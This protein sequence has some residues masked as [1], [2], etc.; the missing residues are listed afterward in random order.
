MLDAI[1][2]L[3]ADALIGF[4]TAG[5]LK[6]VSNADPGSQLLPLVTRCLLYMAVA[7]AYGAVTLTVHALLHGGGSWLSC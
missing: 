6:V 5:L 7:A 3:T 4:A 1:S 2:Y